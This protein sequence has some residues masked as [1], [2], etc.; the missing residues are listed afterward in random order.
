[1]GS[2]NYYNLKTKN[3]IPFLS[4]SFWTFLLSILVSLPFVPINNLL[5]VFKFDLTF[6]VN[7]IFLSVFAM[8]FGTSIYFYAS[9]ELGPRRASSFI[10]LVPFTAIL[11]SMYFLNEPLQLS[12][13]LGGILGIFSVYLINAK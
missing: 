12:T 1:M 6:W 3:K 4:Y 13:I 11:F 2:S 8:A 5:L 9:T 7:L 10:F